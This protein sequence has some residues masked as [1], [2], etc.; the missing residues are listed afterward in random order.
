MT[1]STVC[2]SLPSGAKQSN[3]EVVTFI[4]PRRKNQ[5]SKAVEL[6]KKVRGT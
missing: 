3:V 5:L 1:N 4:D 2:G 6:V